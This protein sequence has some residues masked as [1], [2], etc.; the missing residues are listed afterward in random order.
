MKTKL[1]YSS[2]ITLLFLTIFPAC[3]QAPNGA[4]RS[5]ADKD[6]E[7]VAQT[8]MTL[9]GAT[10][11]GMQVSKAT[12]VANENLSEVLMRY[13]VSAQTIAKIGLLPREDFN[14]RHLQANKDYTVI[15]PID[16]NQNECT[17]VYHPNAIDYVA[18]RLEDSV[19]VY[20]GQNPVDT[21]QHS[22]S[23]VINTSLYESIIDAGGSPL[24]V[25]KLADVY[26]WAIDF[27]G[28]QA[29]DCYK[30]V[31]ES[32]AV[33]GEAAG[34]GDIKTAVFTHNNK[35]MFAFS[36]DQG[37]G[38]EY[39]DEKG[40]SL[41]KTFLKAPLQFSRI[42]SHFSYSRLHPILKIRRPHLGVD[43][44][45]PR[46]TPVYSVGDGT[47][48]SIG[49]SGGAGKMIKIKHN[50]NFMT[51][52][53]HLNAYASGMQKGRS[54]KQGE[55]IGYVGSTGLSTGP[56]LDFRFYKNGKPVDPL[57]I[58]PPSSNPIDIDCSDEYQKVMKTKIQ[59]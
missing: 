4:L 38:S 5:D 45:A 42:S 22:L 14:V 3:R 59:M 10:L 56:H 52:Y 29:G 41:R 57:K 23:G 33:E 19:S 48:I 49:Y 30:V 51:A 18:L 39:F 35:E 21:L 16:S 28:L 43:Y 7:S 32:F 9:Y 15:H 11:D 2:L 6:T 40:N 17:F 50:G 8:P 24:L 13:G 37:E 47:I 54:V 46:G 1:L 53:L 12:F 34:L 31:Y 58:D 36:F 55:L 20:R 44:A 26:A 25:N 27:F